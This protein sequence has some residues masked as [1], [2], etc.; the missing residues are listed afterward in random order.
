[1]WKQTEP[2]EI[3]LC[4]GKNVLNFALQDGSRGVTI[5]KFRLTP[6]R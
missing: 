4:S 6:V 2:V 3:T 5:K 1:M